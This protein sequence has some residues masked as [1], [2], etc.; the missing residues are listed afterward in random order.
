MESSENILCKGEG[1]ILV[2]VFLEQLMAL[3]AVVFIVG[4]ACYAYRNY[5]RQQKNRPD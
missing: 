4:G 5:R 2:A 1:G 3:I